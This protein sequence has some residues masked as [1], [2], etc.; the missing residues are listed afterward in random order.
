MHAQTSSNVVISREGLAQRVSCPLSA[1]ARR[2]RASLRTHLKG[3]RGL[4]GMSAFQKKFKVK[5]TCFC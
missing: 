1:H 2:A 3:G 5:I 4:G